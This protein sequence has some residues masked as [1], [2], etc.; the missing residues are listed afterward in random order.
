M[1]RIEF[2]ESNG[3]QIIDSDAGSVRHLSDMEFNIV[4][5][6]FLKSCDVC[7]TVKPPRTHHCSQCNRCV[8]R[9]DHHCVWL[10]NCVGLHNMKP[11]LLFLIYAIITC[12]Y[13]FGISIVEFARCTAFDRDDSC[14]AGE[15]TNSALQW[16]RQFNIVVC[17]FGLFFTLMMAFF[18]L[19]LLT[20]QVIRISED[21]T[22]IDKLQIR[23]RL[24]HFQ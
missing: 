16:L 4:Q 11:F 5:E 7:E 13:S 10:N 18:L 12:G 1:S 20:S 19:A 17:S 9:M 6:K 24:I 15:S 3:E 22:Y 2:S 8:V 14:T 21:L 23:E